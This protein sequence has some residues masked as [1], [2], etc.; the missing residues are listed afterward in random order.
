MLGLRLLIMVLG[1]VATTTG[2]GCSASRKPSNTLKNSDSASANQSATV[3]KIVVLRDGAPSPAAVA[4]QAESEW[5]GIKGFIFNE[6]LRGFSISLSATAAAELADSPDIAYMVDD[7]L[8]QNTAV[9]APTIVQTPQA[10]TVPT[11][12]ARVLANTTKSFLSQ[13]D[14]DATIAVLDTGVDLTHP[15]LN[16][17][18]SVSFVGDDSRGNDVYGHGTH[19]AGTL[20]ARFNDQGVVG[21]APGAKLWAV[22]VLDDEG[23]GYL[24]QII[25]GIEYVTQ[26]S[27]KIDIV[28]MSLGGIGD[29]G[30][31][32]GGATEDPYHQAIC[33]SVAKGIVYVAAAGNN[34]ADGGNFLPAAYPEVI[35]VSAIVDT[36][37]IPGGRG[38]AST[39]GADD[40]FASFS[41]FGSTVDMAAPG[42]SVLSTYPNGQYARISGTS[43]ATPHIAGAAALYIARN[44]AKKPTVSAELAKYPEVVRAALAT[45]GFQSGS[46]G[47]FTGDRDRYAEPL[48]NVSMLDPK[49]DPALKLEVQIDK[50]QYEKDKDSKAILTF[51]VMD[52]NGDKVG[53]LLPDNFKFE[54]NG[55]TLTPT[56]LALAPSADTPGTWTGSLNL[57]NL[58]IG[59]QT[60]NTTV[61]DPR[62]LTASTS[63]TFELKPNQDKLIRVSAVRYTSTNEGNRRRLVRIA[64]EV[65][66]ANNVLIPGVQTTIQVDYRTF[67]GS[68]SRRVGT[69]TGST[70]TQGLARFV[71]SNALIG[72]YI[73]K[74][75]LL[76]KT[77]YTWDKTRDTVSLSSCSNSTSP[78]EAVDLPSQNTP[79][80]NSPVQSK[81][82]ADQETLSVE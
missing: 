37:G 51:I 45:A 29:A 19:V 71:V 74:I 55:N 46:S 61:T 52:E 15:D 41:N 18:E 8:L 70:G 68:Q 73:T 38:S 57:A 36:D 80:Q 76:A 67:F 66:N 64:V 22:K 49:V 54:L 24:S 23:S 26:N 77:G 35:A 34:A 50:E 40:A 79:V 47:Y 72:C 27:D 28:N 56:D 48:L 43:M 10:E 78:T 82:T 9:S 16:V 33:N 60:L 62:M 1:V 63:R 32:C 11:N 2:L 21:V 14:V 5:N 20:A 44:R 65:R 58:S 13:A 53:G 6:A 3:R 12:I 17:V 4:A 7:K 42:V 31:A 25:A 81:A 39:R 75:N 30:T 69:A 59:S